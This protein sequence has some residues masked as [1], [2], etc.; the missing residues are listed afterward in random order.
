MSFA[1]L[2]YPIRARAHDRSPFSSAL[3][4][5]DGHSGHRELVE[6]PAVGPR[7]AD[8]QRARIGAVDRG[9]R[10][11]AAV[12]DAHHRGQQPGAR[13]MIGASESADERVPHIGARDRR[14]IREAHA[15]PQAE[16][17]HQA[18]ARDHRRLC[19][20]EPGRSRGVAVDESD[21]EMAFERGAQRIGWA[22][23]IERRSGVC[24]EPGDDDGRSSG[25]SATAD[26]DGRQAERDEQAN[27]GAKRTGHGAH[28]SA[29][30]RPRHAGAGTPRFS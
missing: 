28:S 22:I 20:P 9:Y 4:E 30:A 11:P 24:G 5:R 23:R 16:R 18:I 29:R 21:G 1:S 26:E 13:R 17:P 6:E 2:E 25:G 8:G 7:Q 3:P 10:R 14:A 12:T 27:C 15:G 19:K